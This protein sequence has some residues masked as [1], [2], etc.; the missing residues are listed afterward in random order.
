VRGEHGKRYMASIRLKVIGLGHSEPRVRTPLRV[1]PSQERLDLSHPCLAS[2]IQPS[3]LLPLLPLLT[4]P[5]PW[6]MFA[7]QKNAPGRA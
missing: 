1:T 2:H 7:P 4:L 3:S 6:R 5:T